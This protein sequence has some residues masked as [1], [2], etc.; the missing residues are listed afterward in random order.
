MTSPLPP[1]PENPSQPL[2]VSV[3]GAGIAGLTAA[4]ALRRNGHH[5]KIFETSENKTEISAGISVQINS[6]RV[7]EHLGLAKENLHAVHYDGDLFCL[8]SDLHDELKRLAIGEGEGPPAK[9]HLGSKV[10]A[11][12]PEEGTLTLGNGEA[13]HADLILGAD[14][15]H[16]VIR[17]SVLGYAQKA[18]ASGVSCFRGV[19]DASRI[20]EIPEL[21]WCSEGISGARCVLTSDG[22]PFRMFF[23][24]PCHDG[25]V[26][27]FVGF[28]TDEHQDDPGWTSTTTREELL[29]AFKNFHPK[30]RRVL[31]L[32]DRPILKWQVRALPLLPTWIRGRTALIGDAAHA[33]F[34]ML[35]QGAAMAIEEG[36]ALGCLLPAGTVRD[37]VAARLVA[38]QTLRK[39]RGDFVNTESLEEASIPSKRGEYIR[40]RE[41]Q[42]YL[43]GYNAIEAAQECC[44]THFG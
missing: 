41:I 23:V 14:G 39:S 9:L 12:D 13:I 31:D 2:N 24:Y 5:V 4:I 43:K 38:Y 26:I 30:F 19:F 16:S 37:E 3:V 10:L 27:N 28:Y 6:L 35:G 8:R 7:L 40:S 20:L 42:T 11:C 34:P 25:S 29:E 36:G 18:P 21:T 33:T 15:I 17:T 44:R 1:A 22:E 32:A